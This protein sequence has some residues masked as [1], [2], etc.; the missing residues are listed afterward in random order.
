MYCN[1]HV[2]VYV[3]SPLRQ[4]MTVIIQR[5]DYNN[6]RAITTKMKDR[7]KET[8]IQIQPQLSNRAANLLFTAAV[9]SVLLQNS[10]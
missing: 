10:L 6:D 5:Y 2:Y 8:C 4:T 1:V 3:Y 9:N 7:Q